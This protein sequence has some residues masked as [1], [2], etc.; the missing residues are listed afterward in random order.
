[1]LLPIFIER[2]RKSRMR[3]TETARG[4]T[5]ILPHGFDVGLSWR[6]NYRGQIFL[7]S[8]LPYLKQFYN[9]DLMIPSHYTVLHGSIIIA[10]SSPMKYTILTMLLGVKSIQNA[11]DKFFFMFQKFPQANQL[12]CCQAYLV[13]WCF[14]SHLLSFSYHISNES[15]WIN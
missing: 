7:L 12:Y 9:R 13:T 14:S 4:I 11:S 10:C 1:M 2:P 5:V 8:T 6:R 15:T 3:A